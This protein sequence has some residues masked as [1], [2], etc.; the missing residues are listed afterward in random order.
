MMVNTCAAELPC[1]TAIQFT[2]N[3]DW[4]SVWATHTVNSIRYSIEPNTTPSCHYTVLVRKPRPS[5]VEI[6]TDLYHSGV[7]ERNYYSWNNQCFDYSGSSVIPVS[8]L[9]SNMMDE[10]HMWSPP[11]V[12]YA[13]SAA[14]V[15]LESH[16]DEIFVTE[17]TFIPLYQ[18]RLPLTYAAQGFYNRLLGWGFEFPR[19]IDFNWDTYADPTQRRRAFVDELHRLEHQYTAAQLAAMYAPFAQHN[20]DTVIALA[21]LR[22]DSYAQWRSCV[23]SKLQCSQTA[24]HFIEQIEAVPRIN[25]L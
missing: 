16:D 6:M 20:K 7:L 18:R 23:K 25:T 13:D 14:S 4:P 12:A 22:P 2:G 8:T 5:R 21:A 15:V 11:A 17:K 10:Q 1:A 24:L 19:E 3:Q 9:D